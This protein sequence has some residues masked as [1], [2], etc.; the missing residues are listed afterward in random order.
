MPFTEETALALARRA[1]EG[2]VDKAGRP[3]IEHP[4][5]V[6][7]RLGDPYERMAAALHDV[8]EDTDVTVAGLRDAGCPEPVIA[9]VDALT[10]RP[11]EPLEE[12]MRRA[13]ADPIAYQ[14][15]L[16]DIADNGD[17]ARLSLLDPETAA[18]LR[19]KYAESIRLLTGH[20][21]AGP[22]G[23]TDGPPPTA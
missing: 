21:G 4:M 18:R 5:R 20:H 3:Y 19:R 2:Q 9:A 8:L 16:A 14:V 13:A 11:G 12:S 10:K 6:M 23:R 7:A 17:P 22:G 1:H 15:K